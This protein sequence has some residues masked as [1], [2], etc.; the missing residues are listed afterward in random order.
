VP[1]AP[2]GIAI[3]LLDQVRYAVAAVP[4]DSRR[5]A[6]CCGDQLV[7]DYEHA[8]ILAR[9]IAL[10]QNIGADFR[11][12]CICRLYLC[13]VAKIYSYT[14]SLVAIAGL[15]YYRSTNFARCA[16]R[17]FAVPHGS[18]SRYRNPGRTQQR[19]C[20]LLIL[21]NRLRNRSSHIRLSGLYA[22]LAASPPEL[23]QTAIGQPAKRYA[24]S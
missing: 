16:P 11:C 4:D 2:P 1:L 5:I 8:I 3:D 10:D 22:A 12:D 9:N 21:C 15:D 14:F 7:A 6:P 13:T 19:S 23:N 18:A 24:P 17:I 20:Q